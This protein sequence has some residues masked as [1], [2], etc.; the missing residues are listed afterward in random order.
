[1]QTPQ[2]TDPPCE[3]AV[4]FFQEFLGT[5][6]PNPSDPS[7]QKSPHITWFCPASTLASRRVSYQC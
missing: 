7:L 5:Q 1:M 4:I 2:D 6:I 3:D